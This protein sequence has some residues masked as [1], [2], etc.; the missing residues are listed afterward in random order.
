MVRNRMPE[1]FLA[2]IKSMKQ[3]TSLLLLFISVP[4][5]GQ[6]DKLLTSYE[7]SGFTATSTYAEGMSF[8][9][10]LAD[11]YDEVTIQE[12]GMTDI[13]SEIIDR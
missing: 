1:V 9:R 11:R 6:K 7:K 2:K 10:K 4:L 8:Y 3:L 12:H 13:G 5:F